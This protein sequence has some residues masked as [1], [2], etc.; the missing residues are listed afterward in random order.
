MLEPERHDF[1]PTC[2][3][4]S[5]TCQF[6]LR[7]W[8]RENHEKLKGEIAANM[9]TT[10]AWVLENQAKDNAA[11]FGQMLAAGQGQ[12]QQQ[13]QFAYFNVT[14]QLLYGDAN[15]NLYPANPANGQVIGPA[16]G[17][18][19]FQNGQYWAVDSFGRTWLATRV[20]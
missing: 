18:V 14:G 5:I 16:N 10:N 3:E 6:I 20:Q 9:Y 4:P 1:D 12:Q 13:Q 7:W 11:R 15:G 17:R 2:A 19:F 8:L